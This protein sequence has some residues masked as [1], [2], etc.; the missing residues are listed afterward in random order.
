MITQ[1]PTIH[2]GVI[3]SL[4][5][6][7]NL[8]TLVRLETIFDDVIDETLPIYAYLEGPYVGCAVDIYLWNDDLVH[9]RI[10]GSEFEVEFN[11]GKIV[12]CRVLQDY[13]RNK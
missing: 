1:N 9:Q 11:I 6:Q 4:E 5:R 2:R 3:R 12:A 13:L 7:N 10:V 8:L